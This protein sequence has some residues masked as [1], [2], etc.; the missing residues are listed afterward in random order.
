MVQFL[1]ATFAASMTL[2][3]LALSLAGLFYWLVRSAIGRARSFF[4]WVVVF[5][6]CGAA[7][8]IGLGVT[9]PH[10]S[11]AIAT[12]Y[13][14]GCCLII[15]LILSMHID[16][17]Y[18]VGPTVTVEVDRAWVRRVNGPSYFLVG[19]LSGVAVTFCPLFLYATGYR[20]TNTP[21]RTAGVVACFLVIYIVPMFHMRLAGHVASQLRK[22]VKNS[23][24]E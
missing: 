15:A 22:A 8:S 12:S 19:A 6:A 21:I 20:G 4:D 7:S 24:G 14:D 5:G 9:N 3:T 2:L 1:L 23:T 17:L 16:R 11:Y 18:S 10:S 13:F